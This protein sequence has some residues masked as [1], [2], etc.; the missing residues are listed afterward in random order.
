[1]SFFLSCFIESWSSVFVLLYLMIVFTLFLLIP[2]KTIALFREQFLKPEVNSTELIRNFV[3]H[4]TFTDVTCEQS[5]SQWG[6][7]VQ[8]EHRFGIF[9]NLESVNSILKIL[10]KGNSQC[11]LQKYCGETKFSY[12]FDSRGWMEVLYLL[13][14]KTVLLLRQPPFTVFSSWR[15]GYSFMNDYKRNP[16]P[17]SLPLSDMN[18][19]K[20]LSLVFCV[21]QISV[22][23]VEW[24]TISRNLPILRKFKEL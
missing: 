10:S 7:E 17:P 5:A 13:R 19:E 9:Q 2:L 22:L 16:S 15:S 14:Y 23:S 3:L 12:I 1:L 24:W 6:M 21:D 20:N 4:V 18:F 8:H 11:P